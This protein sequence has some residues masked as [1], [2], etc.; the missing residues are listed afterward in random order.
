MQPPIKIQPTIVVAIGFA[1]GLNLMAENSAT[2]DTFA[3]KVIRPGMV[4]GQS[5]ASADVPSQA[6]QPMP[7]LTQ[8]VRQIVPAS[9]RERIVAELV[10]AVQITTNPLGHYKI[11]AEEEKERKKTK[12][13]IKTKSKFR[14]GSMH[15]FV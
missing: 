4:H 8:S 5:F 7:I 13:F 9:N 2:A 3:A 14:F 15:K 6:T 11:A 10:N 1:T 12:K